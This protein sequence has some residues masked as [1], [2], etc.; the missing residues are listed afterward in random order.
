MVFK[1]LEPKQ[2]ITKNQ[3]EPIIHVFLKLKLYEVWSLKCSYV[4]YFIAPVAALLYK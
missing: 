2:K 1:T 3:L 4:C